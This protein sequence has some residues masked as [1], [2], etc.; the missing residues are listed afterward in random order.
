M[1]AA[2]SWKA[3]SGVSLH[4]DQPVGLSKSSQRPP[5]PFECVHSCRS[6]LR[7]R[8]HCHHCQEPSAVRVALTNALIAGTCFGLAVSRLACLTDVARSRKLDFCTC[9]CTVNKPFLSLS[10]TV[11]GMCT[12]A[13]RSVMRC[14]DCGNNRQTCC[15]FPGPFWWPQTLASSRA[16]IQQ[17]G[18][19]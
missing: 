2:C 7:G 16:P 17:F 5:I 14:S 11:S 15:A 18:S 19:L 3:S 10:S 9:S 12:L 1:P 13:W 8:G 6:S 4:G